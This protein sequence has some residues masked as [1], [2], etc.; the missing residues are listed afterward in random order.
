MGLGRFL[1]QEKKAIVDKWFQA[2]TE[3]Y[4]PE[5]ARLLKAE[6]NE[7]ANPVGH[8]SHHG[9]EGVYNEFI[10]Q[11]ETDKIIPFLD[12]II[13][14]RAIQDFSPSQAVAFVFLL[15][16]IVRD[17]IRDAAETEPVS[18]EELAAFDSRVD[19]LALLAF[20]IYMQCRE[21]LFEVRVAEVKSQTY[22]LLQMANL[23]GEIPER[24]SELKDGKT[25]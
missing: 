6:S 25:Q 2:V 21:K 5:T 20:D 14:I 22:R 23:L 17:R 11:F 8:A 15:K 1:V 13:R 10:Q 12:R 3:T 4:A 19:G 16:H 9:L 18:P 7:F 24:G